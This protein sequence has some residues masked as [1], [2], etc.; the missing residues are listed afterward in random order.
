MGFPV[1]VMAM[2]AMLRLA[3]GLIFLFG[4]AAA[5]RPAILDGL[6][7]FIVAAKSMWGCCWKCQSEDSLSIV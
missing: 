6:Q 1:L 5:R 7:D 2:S 4:R 3:I